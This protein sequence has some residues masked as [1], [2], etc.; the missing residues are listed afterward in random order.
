MILFFVTGD[1]AISDELQRYSIIPILLIV[2]AKTYTQSIFTISSNYY[3]VNGG[4]TR[5]LRPEL[6]FNFSDGAI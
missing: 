2:Q 6:N 1:N 3:S 4:K 5:P